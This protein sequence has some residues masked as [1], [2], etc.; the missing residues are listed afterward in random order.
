[1]TV[2]FFVDPQHD[3]GYLSLSTP[4]A[5]HLLVALGYDIENVSRT[6]CLAPSDLLP[7]IAAIRRQIA[8]GRGDEFTTDDVD[9]PQ[10]LR[11]LVELEKVVSR[12]FI[13]GKNI[14]VL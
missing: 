4:V 14:V 8:L 12:A 13:G 10:L 5:C 3:S 6:D 2:V 7:R 9:E 11:H 1:M